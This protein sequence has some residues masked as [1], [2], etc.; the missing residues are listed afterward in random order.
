MHMYA[1]CFDCSSQQN[2]TS[3]SLAKYAS[4][5]NSWPTRIQK[6]PTGTSISTAPGVTSYARCES[7]HLLSS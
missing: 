7:M 1:R 4:S 5:A 6:L 3:M 2:R